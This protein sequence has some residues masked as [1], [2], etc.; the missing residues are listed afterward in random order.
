MTQ[1]TKG[2]QTG[3]YH[4]D[5]GEGYFHTY[6][7]IMIGNEEPHKIHI[8]LPPDYESSSDRYPVLYLHDGHAIFGDSGRYSG[9]WKVSETLT[10]LYHNRVIE[11]VIA[12]AIIPNDRAREYSHKIWFS[13]MGGGG[14]YSYAAWTC[15]HLK[16][17]VD[18]NYRTRKEDGAIIGSSLGGL[19]SFLIGL[20]YPNEFRCIGSLSPAYGAGIDNQKFYGSYEPDSRIKDSL[21]IEVTRNG[22]QKPFNERPKIWMSWGL[23]RN[24]G[25][26]NEVLEDQC[27]RRGREMAELLKDDFGFRQGQDL[28]IY[29]DAIGG[30]EEIA[31]AYHFRLFV[32][33]FYR[34]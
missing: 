18:E 28:Y 26:H 10:E 14:V 6:D 19:A 21:L 1:F 15:L 24:G 16:K 25:Y 34:L 4:S 13:K 33:Q 11:K 31:W 32:E 17:W 8:F 7:S 20:F 2:G 30:H 12:C 5:S 9:S 3:W 29:E 27:A 23:R 22:L